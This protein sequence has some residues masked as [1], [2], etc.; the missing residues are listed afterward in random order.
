MSIMKK[1]LPSEVEERLRQI[2]NAPYAIALKM[3]TVSVGN[4]EAVVRMPIK[5]MT[6]ALGNGHGGAVYSV[7]DQAFALAANSDG[8]PQVALTVSISY[9]KPARGDLVAKA[10]KVGESRTTGVYEVLVH[11]SE[12][13]VAIFQGIGY[14]LRKRENR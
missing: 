1:D 13:L 8:D 11:D 5:G 14:R 10:R 3:E 12:Q 4:G 7:A 2:E 9:L 6:N